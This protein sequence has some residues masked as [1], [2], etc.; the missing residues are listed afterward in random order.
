VAGVGGACGTPD[1]GGVAVLE[2]NKPVV[3]TFNCSAAV[4]AFVPTFAVDGYAVTSNTVNVTTVY[5]AGDTACVALS[6]P[7]FAAL[8][9][10]AW[11]GTNKQAC[12]NASGSLTW[13]LRT[14]TP[15]PASDQC[16]KCAPSYTVDN[17]AALATAG[18]GV[19]LAASNATA[20]VPCAPCTAT[21]QLNGVVTHNWDWVSLGRGVGAHA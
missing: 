12:Y 16:L 9:A 2:A 15:A 11:A 6:D 8:E 1:C 3:C 5:V 13:D 19:P 18:L 4:T 7:L 14:R 10:S 21:V 20:T 17:A